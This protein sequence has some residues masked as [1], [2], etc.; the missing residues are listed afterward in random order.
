M[1]AHMRMQ[2]QNPALANSRFRFNEV[3]SP[4]FNLHRL[5]LTRGSSYVPLPDWIEKKKAI[6]NPHNND[7]ECFKWV[8]IAALEIG[9]DLPCASN[10]KKFTDDYD[11]SGLEFPVAINKIGILERKNDISVTILA[12]KR[13]EVYIARKSERKSSKNV[14]L[15]LI[16]NSECRQ[17]TAI[18]SLSKLL[19]SRNS[20]QAHKQYFCLNCLQGFHS[21]ISRDKHY[22]HCKDNEAVRIEMPKLGSFIEFHDGQNQFKVPFMM[23]AD[24]EAILRPVHGPSPNPNKAYTKKVNQHIPSGF[25]IYSKLAYGEVSTPLKLYRGKDCIQVFCDYIKKEARRLYHMFLE[26]PMEPLTSEEWKGYNQATKCHIC[27]KPFEEHNPKVRDHCHYTGKYRGPAHRNCNLRYKIPL[28]IPIIL[29]NLSG[30]DVHLF[31]RELGKE[32]NKIRVI[33]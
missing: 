26:K 21:E 6:I 32:T 19:G 3:L 16:T 18:K 8:V 13:P 22:E 20:K 1:I 9:K 23:Y 33:K 27:F 10:L 7:E 12:L 17:Y 30:Y 24:F 28:Q 4:D 11:W 2:I 29:H 14:K 5:N 15:L 31:I 25:C